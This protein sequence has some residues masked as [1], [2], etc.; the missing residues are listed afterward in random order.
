MN[1][2]ISKTTFSGNYKFEHLRNGAVIDAWEDNNLIPTQ[3]LNFIL[4][5]LTQAATTKISTWYLGIG[6]GNYTVTAGDTGAAIPGV[7][8]ANESSAY[9]EATRPAVTFVASTA[10]T[11]NN[12][13]A[14]ATFTA[15][16]AVT[17]TNAFLVSTAPKGDTNGTLLSSLKLATAKTLA[18]GDQ[19]IVTFTLTAA[20]V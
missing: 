18:S 8:A 15:N 2:M 20:S 16:G 11:T 17:V 7:G 5:V 14:K 10:A 13:A 12:S 9:A 4:N 6:T 19:L 1:A 3:G